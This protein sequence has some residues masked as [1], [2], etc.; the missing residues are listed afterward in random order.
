MDLSANSLVITPRLGSSN[1]SVSLYEPASGTR[2]SYNYTVLQNSTVLFDY[3][4][5]YP[6]EIKFN[7]CVPENKRA[8]IY[9]DAPPESAYYNNENGRFLTFS[10]ESNRSV[11]KI[12]YY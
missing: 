2:L 8:H 6:G 11:Y 1:G 3:E 12:M 4:T 5:T 10:S 7:F 9:S